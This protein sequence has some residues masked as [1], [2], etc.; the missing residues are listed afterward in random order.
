[1]RNITRAGT[2]EDVI[3]LDILELDVAFEDPIVQCAEQVKE[4]TGD[5]LGLLVNNALRVALEPPGV[6][7]LMVLI[8]AVGTSIFTNSHPEALKTPPNSL[9]TYPAILRRCM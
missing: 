6:R 8:G 1:M 4:R 2:L 5:S 3:N 7:A 9:R